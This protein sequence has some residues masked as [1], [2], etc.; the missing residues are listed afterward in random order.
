MIDVED[1][2]SVIHYP[3]PVDTPEEAVI[4][5][6]PVSTPEVDTD[7]TVEASPSPNENDNDDGTLSNDISYDRRA[8][9]LRGVDEDAITQLTSDVEKELGARAL[10]VQSRTTGSWL[11]TLLRAVLEPN[12][13]ERRIRKALGEL[14]EE[15]RNAL[16]SRYKNDGKVLATAAIRQKLTPGSSVSLSGDDA[17]IAFESHQRGAFR[18][19]LYNSGITLDLIVPT[20]NDMNM[21]ISNC[22]IVDTQLGSSSGAHYFLYNDLMFKAQILTFL[23]PLIVNSSFMDWQKGNQLWS[24]IKLPDL[25]AIVA[26]LAAMCYK[27]GFEGFT[28]ACTRPITP[29][30]PKACGHVEKL[31]VDIFKMIVTRFSVLSTDAINFMTEARGGVIKHSV[32]QIAEYQ[33]KLGL[34]GDVLT[35]GNISFT[36]RVPT[37]AEHTEA[38]SRFLADVINEVEGDNSAARYEQMGFRYVR[39]F[40]PWIANVTLR[41]N[42]GADMN[43]N[44]AR[45]ITRRLE[46]IDHDDAEGTM[47]DTFIRYIN[48]T[49]LTYVGYPVTA[50]PACNFTPDTPSGMW[51]FDP[52]NAFFTIAF[53]YLTQASSPQTNA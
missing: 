45:V 53:L 50:C 46:Q 51:T 20:G 37:L 39:T 22:Q 27:D 10:D 4:S 33:S 41:G 49:Q 2:D 24:I 26:T 7:D 44:E 32:S 47:R 31:T 28:N 48:K 18:I 14:S 38:G 8:I 5:T 35:F 25:A 40:L 17:L 43:T 16:S 29:E 12:F 34:E 19:P 15:D 11:N 23:R 1:D 3:P 21:L 6:P 36:L 13:E 42:D 30:H 52:F 9:D